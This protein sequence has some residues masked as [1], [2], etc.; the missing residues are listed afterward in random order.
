LKRPSQGSLK[1]EEIGYIRAFRVCWG[2]GTF[3]GEKKNANFFLLAI[4]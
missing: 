2:S 1:R 3:F 4:L